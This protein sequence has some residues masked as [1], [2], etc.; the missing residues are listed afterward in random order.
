MQHFAIWE[1]FGD[2]HTEVYT[3]HLNSTGLR[4]HLFS[5]VVTPKS[6]IRE[7]DQLHR[8]LNTEQKPALCLPLQWV[9]PS[10][11][12]IT[13]FVCICSAILF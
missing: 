7:Q 12:S 13:C 10:Y 11:L 3:E 2:P 9:V 5:T 8:T 1:H 6:L 4:H